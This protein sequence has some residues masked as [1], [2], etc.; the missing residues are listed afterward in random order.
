MHYNFLLIVLFTLV[1]CSPDN[2]EN[3]P[4]QKPPIIVFSHNL[5]GELEICGCRKKPLGGM[6]QAAGLF[7]ELR[8]KYPDQQILYFDTGDSLYPTGNIPEIFIK[9]HNF[10]AENVVKFF[11]Q[12]NITAFLPGDQD[13]SQGS[14]SFIKMTKEH[15]LPMILSNAAKDYKKNF[16]EHLFYEMS[17]M[18]IYF[19]GVLDKSTLPSDQQS[20]VIDSE[21]SIKQQI[22]E[23]NKIHG[24]RFPAKQKMMILLSHSGM[25]KDK[26]LAKLY[27]EFSWI[28]GSHS[29]AFTQITELVGKTQI[30]Q[31]LSRNHHMGVIN[32]AKIKDNFETIEL[33][34][35]FSEYDGNNIWEKRYQTYQSEL[36]KIK[37]KELDSIGNE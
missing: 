17:N 33:N 11:K 5:H 7:E 21:V 28:I 13:L 16:Q 34:D 23:I 19:V 15:Q 31:V 18:V 3:S 2:G 27:P 22:K 10:A 35:L 6:V 32:L 8:L 1:S 26:Q 20:L 4:N 30:V 9:S 14:D 12:L 37:E 29:Q 36:K 24:E 25:Q